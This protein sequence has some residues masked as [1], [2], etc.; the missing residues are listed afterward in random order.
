LSE[1]E[2][3]TIHVLLQKVRRNIETD[4]EYVKKGNKRNY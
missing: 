4:W 1:E 2:V 3:E